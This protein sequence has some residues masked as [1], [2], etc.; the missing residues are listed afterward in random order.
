MRRT[1]Y[2]R[3]TGRAID[4][5]RGG[6]GWEGWE[7]VVMVVVVVAVVV[8]VVVAVVHVPLI[9]TAPRSSKVQNDAGMIRRSYGLTAVGWQSH[10]RPIQRGPAVDSRFPRWVVPTGRRRIGQI[11]DMKT[12]DGSM[13]PVSSNGFIRQSY[14]P[15]TAVLWV[16][17]RI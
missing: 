13:R 1:I 6:G 15:C 2:D 12:D 16:L 11:D 17:P 3:R 5:A 8:M 4:M 9:P 10:G 7:G 14:T